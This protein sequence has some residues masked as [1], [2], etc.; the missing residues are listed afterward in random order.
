L[1]HDG[2]LKTGAARIWPSRRAE[3]AR[4]KR[5]HAQRIGIRQGLLIAGQPAPED[6][7][8]L[9]RRGVRSVVNLRGEGEEG[10]WDN[11]KAAFE[12]AGVEYTNIPISPA[13]LDD[14]AVTRV[15]NAIES[16]G[17]TTLLH[18]AGGGRAGIMGLL[19]LAVKHGWSLQQTLDEGE[20]R[21]VEWKPD[22]PYRE[23]FESYIK[24]HS[25]AER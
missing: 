24:R 2:H 10:F 11:E 12:S 17:G 8:T 15:H 9:R 23:F 14:L 25:P 13:E 21:G 22:S 18:C 3:K 7:D 19:H 16:G 5:H 20:K 4:R 1:Y 6:V